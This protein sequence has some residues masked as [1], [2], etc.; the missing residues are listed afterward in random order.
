MQAFVFLWHLKG[1]MGPIREIPSWHHPG[2]NASDDS[3]LTE[4]QMEDLPEVLISDIVRR[5]HKTSDQNSFSLVSKHFYTI[6]ADLRNS[7]RVGCGLDPAAEALASLCRRFPNLT[8]VEIAYSGWMSTFG[9]QLDNQALSILSTNC[10]SL[11]DLTLSFCSFI[12]DSGL[13]CLTSCQKLTSLKLNFAPAISSSGL[14]S[15]VV[16]C[17]NLSMLHLIHCMKVTSVE[18]LEYIG[19]MGSLEDLCIVKCRGISEDSLVKLGP[20]WKR[21]RRLEFRK[22]P[23]N[24]NPKTHN[25]FSGESWHLRQISCEILKEVSLV[26]CV[27][28]PE[29]GLSFLLSSCASLEKLTLDTCTGLRDSDFITLSQN[30]HGLRSISLRLFSQ[31]SSY[32][33][34]L[35]DASF[36]ALSINCPT[37]EEVELAFCDSEFPA[38]SSITIEGILAVINSCSV[39]V[40]VLKSACFFND[41]AMEALSS[42]SFLECLEIERCQEVTDFG[43]GFVSKFPCLANLTICKC[44]GVTDD[45]LK[46]LVESKMLDS[47]VVKDCPRISDQG[48]QGVARRVAY[49]QDL[50]WLF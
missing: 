47:L 29:R 8:K 41:V 11:T 16:G 13:R 28:E 5:L 37:L 45:G 40:L 3:D 43:I 12:T 33:A 19:K 21:L 44:L 38:A 30:S 20:G 42:A 18:W 39:R 14:L 46:L 1:I 36:R 32:Q 50:S 15:I 17:K 22:D 25:P 26:N 6:E 35:T 27:I 23:H 7:I 9:K 31:S 34:T 2:D 49:S 48:V 24:M 10:Q 4:V